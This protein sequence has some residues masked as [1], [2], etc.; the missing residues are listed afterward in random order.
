MKRRLR[1]KKLHLKLRL[2]DNNF[3]TPCD[4]SFDLHP[5]HPENP[6]TV[7]RSGLVLAVRKLKFNFSIHLHLRLGTNNRSCCRG[8]RWGVEK[9]SWDPR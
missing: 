4:D 1:K 7:V 9:C 8:W 2:G 5:V 6:A 3:E